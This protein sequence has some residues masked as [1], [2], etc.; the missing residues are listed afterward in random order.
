MD[1][2]RLAEP[3]PV[4]PDPVAVA[5]YNLRT[6]VLFIDEYRGQFEALRTSDAQEAEQMLSA[7]AGTTHR[8]LGLYRELVGLL[9]ARGVIDPTRPLSRK[10]L[11]PGDKTGR[12]SN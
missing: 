12:E 4:E 1:A 7:L 2:D 9:F 11:L 6:E 10:L 5:L 8:A 3:G